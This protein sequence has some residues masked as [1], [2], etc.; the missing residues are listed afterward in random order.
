MRLSTATL[1]TGAARLFFTQTIA[2]WVNSGVTLAPFFVAHIVIGHRADDVF[3]FSSC[4]TRRSG[5]VDPL[6]GELKP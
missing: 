6:G 3:R 4:P 2:A 5:R 1:S